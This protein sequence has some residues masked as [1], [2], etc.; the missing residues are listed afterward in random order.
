MALSEWPVELGP[1]SQSKCQALH[2][3]EEASVRVPAS[4]GLA[5]VTPRVSI[6]FPSF[7]LYPSLRSPLSAADHCHHRDDHAHGQAQVHIQGHYCHPRDHPHNLKD[8][9]MGGF[10]RRNTG[11]WTNMSKDDPGERRHGRG[12]GLL[13][14]IHTKYN[15]RPCVN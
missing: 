15:V 7:Q 5:V 9:G 2:P 13:K 6:S 12:R 11:S 10:S 8:M 3:R 1:L 14:S 4:P